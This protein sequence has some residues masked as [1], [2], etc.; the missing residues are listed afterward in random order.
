MNSDAFRHGDELPFDPSA[1]GGEHGREYSSGARPAIR[2]ISEVQAACSLPG[3]LF[4][5]L[6]ALRDERGTKFT[7]AR[8]VEQD[9]DLAERV[10]KAANS[11]VYLTYDDHIGEH[12]AGITNLPTAV[13]RIGLYA[14]R[15]LAYTQGVCELGGDCGEIGQRIIAHVLVVAEISWSLGSRV[16]RP[17]AEDAY[18]AGLLHDFGKIV[19]LKTLP[20]DYAAI[21]TWCRQRGQTA[22][23]SEEE[24]FRTTQPYLLHH[25]KTGV[26]LMRA[27]SLPEEVLFTVAHHHDEQILEHHGCDPRQLT[28]TV[29]LADLVAHALGLGDG[30]STPP[31]SY[32]DLDQ[33][34]RLAGMPVD[35]LQKLAQEA[36]VRAGD[37]IGA[38][39]TGE[40][41][42]GVEHVRVSTT[43]AADP[44]ADLPQPA[45]PSWGVAASD[46]TEAMT[47]SGL[48]LY[49]PFCYM[50]HG[51]VRLSDIFVRG[52]DAQAPENLRGWLQRN[53]EDRHGEAERRYTT[54]FLFQHYWDVLQGRYG[55]R[56]GRTRSRTRMKEALGVFLID[57]YRKSMGDRPGKAMADK[58]YAMVQK[59]RAPE[60]QVPGGSGG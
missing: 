27:H 4:R 24:C 6:S 37:A 53:S 10:L 38:I 36:V 11:P 7:I 41:P 1:R 21:V 23:E 58:L 35:Q 50:G 30:F 17:Y 44:I 49:L 16:S 2:D 9:P 13:L 34:A 48:L 26:E 3:P 5:V 25:V 29:I 45:S 51:A 39:P 55:E 56:I 12:G 52:R 47:Q 60:L 57:D 28:A 32:R 8:A 42:A 40:L 15:N 18:L 22:C 43:L 54:F 59:S 19:L 31:A 20:E 46:V 14:V 33:L